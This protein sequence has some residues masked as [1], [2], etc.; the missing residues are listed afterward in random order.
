[1]YNTIGLPIA[2][3]FFLPFGLSVHPI[4]ASLAMAFSSVTVVVSSLMLNSWTRPGWMDE[5]AKNGGRAP[6]A[7]RWVSG[8]GIV[9]WVRKMV[10]RR[11]KV[12]KVGYVPLQNIEG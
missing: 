6:K 8:R 1:M 4:M 11:G 10:G 9:G 5:V 3:G 7:E 2:M 12:E